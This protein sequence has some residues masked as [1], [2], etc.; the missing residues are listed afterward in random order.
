MLGPEHPLCSPCSYCSPN[1]PH[2]TMCIKPRFLK[3]PH[4]FL[5][6]SLSLLLQLFLDPS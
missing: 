2:P 3:L 6:V 1:N 5:C 4:P